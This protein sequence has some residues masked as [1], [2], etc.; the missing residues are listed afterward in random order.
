ME[1]EERYEL[2]DWEKEEQGKKEGERIRKREEEAEEGLEYDE[3]ER[4]G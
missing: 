4:R 2:K 3:R 1:Y